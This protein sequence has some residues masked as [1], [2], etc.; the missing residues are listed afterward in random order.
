MDLDPKYGHFITSINGVS[1]SN[2][3][4]WCVYDSNGDPLPVGK[5][6]HHTYIHRIKSGNIVLSFHNEYHGVSNNNPY[7]CV[8]DS[9]GDPLP[10]CK[11]ISRLTRELIYS[12]ID[13]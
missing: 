2:P 13:I 6:P 12:L 7:W 5:K 8:Y 11:N 3:F 9:N 1:N 4:Y 10:V